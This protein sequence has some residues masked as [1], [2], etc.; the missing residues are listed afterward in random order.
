MEHKKEINVPPQGYSEPQGTASARSIVPAPGAS[1]SDVGLNAGLTTGSVFERITAVISKDAENEVKEPSVEIITP[2]ARECDRHRSCSEDTLVIEDQTMG[3]Y[4]SQDVAVEPASQLES[5]VSMVEDEEKRGNIDA[6]N[7]VSMEQEDED[8]SIN[9]AALKR[10]KPQV[11]DSDSLEENASDNIR[12]P[13]LRARTR[14]SKVNARMV[15]THDDKDKDIP[16]TGKNENPDTGRCKVVNPDTGNDSMDATTCSGTDREEGKGKVG[17][18]KRKVRAIDPLIAERE[19]IKKT[20]R[21]PE[22]IE[23]DILRNMTASEISAQ[24]LEYVE[25]I[26]TIRT[27]CGRM[28]G[29]L[30]GEMRKRTCGLGEL[31]RALQLRAEVQGDPESLKNK[32]EELLLE[33]K[34]AKREEEKRKREV[35]ELQE[36][37]EVLRREN[38]DIRLEMRR[39]MR[40]IRESISRESEKREKGEKE[41]NINKEEKVD[42]KY[43]Q[44]TQ[45]MTYEAVENMESNVEWAMRPPLQGKSVPIPIRKN[46]PRISTAIYTGKGHAQS[47]KIPDNIRSNIG[48]K[49][50][51]IKIKSDIQIVPPRET[52]QPVSGNPDTGKMTYAQVAQINA[53]TAQKE[54]SVIGRRGRLRKED[55]KSLQSQPRKPLPKK[56]KI[57][58]VKTAAI[59]IKGKD[60]N[61]SYAEALKKVRSKISLQDLEIV[62]PRIRK[63]MNGAT[64]I[65][66]SGPDNA[67]KADKLATAMQKVLAGEAAVVRP[68]IKGELRLFGMDESVS[69]DEVKETIA[70]EG[71]CMIGEIKTGRIGRTKSGTGVIWVQCP[72]SAAITIAGKKRIQIGWT[73]VRVE[74]LK[75]RPL[76]CRKCWRIGHVKERCKSS[77]DFTGSC[78]RCGTKGHLAQG[79]RNKVKCL[80]CHDI[81]L[82][83]EHRMGSYRCAGITTFSANV[84]NPNVHSSENISRVKNLS[85]DCSDTV[86]DSLAVDNPDAVNIDRLEVV[87]N[88]IDVSKKDIEAP[89]RRTDA[90]EE[91]DIQNND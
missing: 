90:E 77:K 65:E 72:K 84:D 25:D 32:I 50:K 1:S 44:E 47:E 23:E 48:S 39:E 45:D 4:P 40:K 33:I 31:I 15:V 56:E 57:K 78:F 91:M 3:S 89:V 66:I 58:M 85:V 19:I 87:A 61:F 6:S 49:N 9:R 2:E 17:R 27:K 55:P 5:W 12:G 76:Q 53:Q 22:K 80:L 10:K 52:I 34:V 14:R 13:K 81:G 21:A 11:I 73:F 63:G 82:N 64:I 75:A 24:A 59:S 62:A 88:S 68:N 70:I 60:N 74:A 41:G 29:G 51:G 86:I 35:S 37:I 18:P 79:C 46:L 42:R 28:Q 30:S 20:G 16:D 43:T 67:S 36:T 54:W 7:V 71:N 83:S 26:E 8:M 69:V 38:K